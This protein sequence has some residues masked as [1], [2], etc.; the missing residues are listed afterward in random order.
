[1]EFIRN[2]ASHYDLADKVVLWLARVGIAMLIFLIGWW[3]SKKISDAI[4][5]LLNK[6][7]DPTLA[8]F[9]GNILYAI[10]LAFVVIAALDHLGVETTSLLAVVGAAGLAVGLALKDSLSN[11][12]AGVMLILF[13]PFRVGDFVDAGGAMGTV[14]SVRIFHTLL[15]TPNGQL[16][17]IPNGGISNSKITNYSSQ[18]T[19]RVDLKIGVSYDDDLKKVRAVLEEIIKADERVLADPAPSIVVTELADSSVNFAV[20]CWT[21]TVDWWATTCDLLETVKIRFDESGI[22]IPYPQQQLH[23]VQTAAPDK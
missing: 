13:R 15:K 12:A 3:V 11:F 18:P 17:W 10:L 2:L 21:K 8:T 4:T 6:R 19:R 1:M 9:L 5:S 7:T 23:I 20:R 22:T 16:L 14:E